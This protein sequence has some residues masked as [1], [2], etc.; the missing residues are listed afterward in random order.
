MK[1]FLSSP[2]GRIAKRMTGFMGVVTGLLFLPATVLASSPL[3]FDQTIAM[4]W[5]YDPW[6]VS[7]RHQQQSIIAKSVAVAT[8]PDP[9]VSFGIANLPTDTLDFDQE[10]M[11]QL[12]IG[13]SQQF[14]RGDSLALQS[15]QLQLTGD[16]YPFQRQDRR[17]QVA[18]T[19][20][21]LW[22]DVFRAQQSIALINNHRGLFEQL[23]DVAQASYASTLGRTR[24]QDI[25]RAQLELTRLDDRLTMLNQQR[26]IALEQ[27][28]QWLTSGEPSSEV[29]IRSVSRDLPDIKSLAGRWYFSEKSDSSRLTEVLSMHP[30][31]RKL[32]Q[33]LQAAA[34]GVDLARQKYKPQWG[35]NA[36]YGY[37]DDEPESAFNGAR[38]RAD[39]FS[40]A[41][42]LDVPLFTAN[43]QDRE[44]ES[45]VFT[46]ESVK[47]ERWQMLRQMMASFNAVGVKLQRLDQRQSLYRQQLLPQMHELA[48]A[49]LTAYTNDDGDFSEV[50]RSRI[51]ELNAQI[52]ALSIDV[53]R[54]Q[55]ILQ[56]NYFF[57][58][59]ASSRETFND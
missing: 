52:D 46:Q 24:Q 9:Q 48:E 21:Q 19:V 26:E 31:I 28:R 43:R 14:P 57:A 40:V 10:A 33:Q 25:I 2:I 18:V 6:L 5:Q 12:T 41:I 4:A 17:A 56:L 27:L 44:V 49:S 51:A 11:T 32:D 42:T 23:I 30:A 39:L 37:R 8:L 45:A 16:Q 7:N 29:D 3:T 59:L 50:V 47:I 20:G 53:Q 1:I 22:L 35:V 58:G 13:V 38:E 34:T 54:Q 36:S 15:R 55:A